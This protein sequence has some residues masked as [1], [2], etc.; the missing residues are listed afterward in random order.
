MSDFNIEELRNVVL[1]YK[2][3][4]AFDILNSTDPGDKG[5][6]YLI[7]IDNI[8]ALI[9]TKR[10][11]DFR[12][13]DGFDMAEFS[14]T[15]EDRSGILSHSVIQIWFDEQMFNSDKIDKKIISII[16]DQFIDLSIEYLNKFINIYRRVSDQFWIRN[17]VKK[18]IFSYQ[19]ILIDKNDNQQPIFK[20]ATKGGVYF[21]G[22]KEFKLESNKDNLVRNKL[23]ENYYGFKDEMVALMLDNFHLGRFNLALIQGATLFENFIYTE[24]KKTLSNTKLD[25]IKKKEDCGCLVGISEICK[26]GIKE[27]FD[28]DFGAT[29]EWRDI[30]KYMLR[31]RNKIVHG[32]I[33]KNIDKDECEK[34]LIA[35]KK[36]EKLLKT[37]VF[38]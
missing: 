22:G 35:V 20:M 23:L 17:I 16:P 5:E 18:D 14:K 3:P 13:K 31:P 10:I 9:K 7:Q 24:L 2:L 33:L 37:E 15:D 36:G 4:I 6:P 27:Y 25:N 1:Q 29:Q 38:K 21:N 32:E 26:R 34:G 28:F 19:Y 12:W 11:Y 30:Q 8:P